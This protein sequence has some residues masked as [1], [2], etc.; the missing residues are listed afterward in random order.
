MTSA[1]DDGHAR[2]IALLDEKLQSLCASLKAAADTTDVQA[3]RPIIHQPGYTTIAEIEMLLGL[4][5]AAHAQA[6]HVTHLKKILVAGARAIQPQ[7]LPPG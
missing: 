1:Y 7:P 2:Q 5:D 6:E 4:T 3:L